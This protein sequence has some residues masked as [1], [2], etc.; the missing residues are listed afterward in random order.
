VR[1]ASTV[2]AFLAEPIGRYFAGRAFVAWMHDA[3]LVGASHFGAFDEGDEPA[4]RRLYGL[5]LHPALVPPYDVIHDLGAVDV[6]DRRA[7]DAHAAFLA[8]HMPKLAGR[9]RRLAVV[10]PTGLP[11]AA[12]TGLFHDFARPAFEAE[13]FAD[14]VAALAWLGVP[15]VVRAEIG[16]AVASFERVAPLLGRLREHLARDPRG[17]T[18]ARAAK[19]LGHSARSLQRHLASEGTAFRDE[20]MCARVLAAKARLVDSDDKIEVIARELGFRSVAAFTAMFG[21]IAGEPPQE[22][23]RRRS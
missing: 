19:A 12:F 9:V 17:A 22:F 13:L 15:E 20:L 4:L 18:L 16:D 5:A 23:R 8:E 11:G 6:L 14:R 10:R 3:R 7:F 1:A 2:E 21:R